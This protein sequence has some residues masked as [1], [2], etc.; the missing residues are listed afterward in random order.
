MAADTFPCAVCGEKR[1]SGS[2]LSLVG[3]GLVCADERECVRCGE[4]VAQLASL[5]L[6]CDTG[7]CIDCYSADRRDEVTEF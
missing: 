7:L 6:P 3:V 5:Y 1:P 2:L 4:H